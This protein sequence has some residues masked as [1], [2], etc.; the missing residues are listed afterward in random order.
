[1][2]PRSTISLAVA[3][4][5]GISSIGFASSDAMAYRNDRL[6]AHATDR[7]GGAYRG[8]GWRGGPWRGAGWRHAWRPDATAAGPPGTGSHYRNYYRQKCGYYPHAPC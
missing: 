1:M 2:L 5:L 7:H 3:A 4:V 6:G 8:L